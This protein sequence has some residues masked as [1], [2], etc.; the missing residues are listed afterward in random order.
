MGT[1]SGQCLNPQAGRWQTMVW[2]TPGLALTQAERLWALQTE[3]T[4]LTKRYLI[5]VQGPKGGL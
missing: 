2:K 1:T 5:R 4:N 3:M